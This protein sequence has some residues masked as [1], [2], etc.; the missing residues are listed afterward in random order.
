MLQIQSQPKSF[1]LDTE[2]FAARNKVKPQT[3]RARICKTGSY[4]GVV[5]QRLR[6]GRLVWPDVRVMA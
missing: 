4:F 3:I 1:D 6:N 5:P 2:Q